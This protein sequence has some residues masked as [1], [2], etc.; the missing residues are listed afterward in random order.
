VRDVASEGARPTLRVVR[1]EPTAEELAVVTAL[2]A[3]A[4]E[5]APEPPRARRGGWNDPGAAHHRPL[6]P[7]PNGWRASALPRP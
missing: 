1:G 4:G 7:G 6:Q 5:P 2:F 3:A